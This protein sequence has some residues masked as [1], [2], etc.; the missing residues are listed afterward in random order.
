[1]TGSE[2]ARVFLLSPAQCGGL[3]SQLLFRPDAASDLAR[4]LQSA[5]GAS[6]G[7]VMTFLSGLYFRGKLGYARAFARPPAGCPGVLVITPHAGLREPDV[8]VTVEELRRAA[9]VDISADN[10]RY[11]TPLTRTARALCDRVGTGGDVVLLGSVAT[12]KYLEVL[13][14][15]F[16]ERLCFPAEFLGRGDMS[17]GAL[18]LRCVAE[19][20]ELAYIAAPKSLRS[21]SRPASTAR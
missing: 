5:A 16:G 14:P 8:P 3:R 9:S 15:V 17:R 1:M 4:R 2:R 7:E 10:A 19:G 13:A 11:R 20:H 6:L 12:G 21:R 18:M